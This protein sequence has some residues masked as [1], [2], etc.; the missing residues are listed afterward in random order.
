[1]TRI[2]TP[3]PEIDQRIAAA[4]QQQRELFHMH[5]STAQAIYTRLIAGVGRHGVMTE[6]E[7]KSAATR[8]TNA[9]T[10]LL[11][12]YGMKVE[13]RA[14]QPPNNES[15]LTP[16]EDEAEPTSKGYVNQD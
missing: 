9:A 8:S 14:M 12:R 4:A 6:D 3:Q 13:V 11:A 16:K 5:F 10:I 15:K 2:L 7:M 1:M